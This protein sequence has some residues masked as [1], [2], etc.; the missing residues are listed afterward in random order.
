MRFSMCWFEINF[1]ENESF[2]WD[3]KSGEGIS[4]FEQLEPGFSLV[5]YVSKLLENYFLRHAFPNLVSFL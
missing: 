1:P 3:A 2:P 5:L 4:R